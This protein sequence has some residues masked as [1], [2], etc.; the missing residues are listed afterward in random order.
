MMVK[1]IKKKFILSFI[2]VVLT[3]ILLSSNSIF[4]VKTVFADQKVYVGGYAAGFTINTR[5]AEIIGLTEV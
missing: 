2:L 1:F 5:G 3:A 4:G